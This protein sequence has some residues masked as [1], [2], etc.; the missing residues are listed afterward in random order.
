[1]VGIVFLRIIYK[2]NITFISL[3]KL[4]EL[5]I[6]DEVYTTL[7][8]EKAIR[9][10]TENIH[11]LIHFIDELNRTPPVTQNQFDALVCLCFN[12]PTWAKRIITEIINI[13]EKNNIDKIT[14]LWLGFCTV[15]GIFNQGIFSRRQ[16]ELELYFKTC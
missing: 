3:E 8:L 5:D 1:M 13:G 2:F 14:N 6:Y 16:R 11:S 15:N 9:E 10:P 7:N 4:F 12:R